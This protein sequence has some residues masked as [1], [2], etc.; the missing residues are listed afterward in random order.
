[1]QEKQKTKNGV[2]F[3][4]AEGNSKVVLAIKQKV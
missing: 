2:K 1:M 4:Q 3:V